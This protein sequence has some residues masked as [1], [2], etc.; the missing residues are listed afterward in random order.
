MNVLFHH[1]VKAHVQCRMRQVV[2]VLH[3]SPVED[4]QGQEVVDM[5]ISKKLKLKKK[6]T[7]IS[8]K[9]KNKLEKCKKKF[10]LKIYQ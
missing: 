1:G 10:T 7:K 4:G 8:I 3:E 6:F 9:W 2:F 5:K